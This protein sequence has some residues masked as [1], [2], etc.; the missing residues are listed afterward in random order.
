MESDQQRTIQFIKD[1]RDKLEEAIKALV[2]ALNAFAD[3]YSLAPSGVYNEDSM[4]KFG[5]IT[6]SFEAERQ[7]YYGLAVQG[8]YP[9]KKYY[10]KFLGCTEE[11]ADK[12]LAMV[13][14]EQAAPTLFGFSEE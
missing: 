9:W 2:Y 10:T 6:Y 7:H 14:S 4:I 3:L 11:E 8:K 12:L 13:K 1:V 5:S